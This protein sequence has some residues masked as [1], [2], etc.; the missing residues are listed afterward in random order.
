MKCKC[1]MEGNQEI[2]RTTLGSET[3]S[4]NSKLFENDENCF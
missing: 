2:Q 4:S 1:F 3:I